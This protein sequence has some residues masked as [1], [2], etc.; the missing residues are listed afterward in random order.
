[1]RPVFDPTGGPDVLVEK[2]VG[3]AYDTVRRVSLSLP[4][5]QRLDGVLEEIPDLAT[6]VVAAELETQLPAVLVE[7]DSKANTAVTGY[8]GEAVP[9]IMNHIQQKAE[10]IDVVAENV[11]AVAAQAS[12]S[13]V[14]AGNGASAAQSESAR[15]TDEANRAE[16]AA[17]VATLSSTI[18]ET[19]ELGIAGTTDGDYFSTPSA[20]TQEYLIL[21]HHVGAEAI[22]VDSYPSKAALDALGLEDQNVDLTQLAWMVIDNKDKVGWNAIDRTGGPTTYGLKRIGAGLTAVNSPMLVVQIGDVAVT[23]SLEAVGVE[24]LPTINKIAWAVVD[25]KGAISWLQVGLDG[26]PTQNSIDRIVK[27]LPADISGPAKQ[28]RDNVLGAKLID[29]G[30]TI[31]TGGDSLTAGAGGGGTT[32][33]GVLQSL[34]TASGR[35]NKVVPR[36]VGGENTVTIAARLGANP[37][38]IKAVGGVIPENPTL[39]EITLLPINGFVPKPLMQG[40]STFA[41]TIGNVKGVF[42]R[43][44]VG[45]TY[46]YYFTRNESG[47]ALNVNRPTAMYTDNGVES[48]EDIQIIWIGQNGP[49]EE[50]A[51][52]DA[53]AIAARLTSLNKKFLVMSKLAVTGNSAAD[54]A[55]DSV[56]FAEFGRRFIS[57][58]A[59]MVEYGLADAGITPTP[60]DILDMAAGL[61][62]GSLRADRVHLNGAGYTIVGTLVFNRL[63]EFGWI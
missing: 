48:R 57:P 40:P 47:A 5:L 33:P 20:S 46:T 9:P 42:S 53:K 15:A 51:I 19:K 21:W 27:M 50:R 11:D 22:Y 49:S 3:K 45:T 55:V 29:S 17:T 58:R 44:V 52:Q 34:I 7:V 16:Q 30:P 38:L 61:V 26:N 12:N 6:N 28:Y 18:F 2:M 1:M 54:D 35:T 60:Q 39:V 63:V 8:L 25:V 24:D 59:Y 14:V 43:T 10:E 13:A 62:P 36:A 41:V 32:Y 31:T 4:E 37:Y 23:R 56:W